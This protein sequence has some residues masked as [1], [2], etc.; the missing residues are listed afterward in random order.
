[1]M[2]TAPDRRPLDSRASNSRLAQAWARTEET[3]LVI[4]LAALVAI[5]GLQ[6]LLRYVFSLPLVWPEEFA[7]LLL[8]WL[9]FVGM[10]FASRRG[11]HVTVTMLLNLLPQGFQTGVRLFWEVLI[12]LFLLVVM[13][14]GVL[15]VWLHREVENPALGYSV[16]F[17][18]AALPVG[19]VLTLIPVG[20]NIRRLIRQMTFEISS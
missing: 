6:V 16:A 19:A 7:G 3:L 11:S 2:S 17:G 9:S 10:A 14:Q 5:G 8:L 13:W 1:M 20:A 15:L 4:L 12:G 18:E